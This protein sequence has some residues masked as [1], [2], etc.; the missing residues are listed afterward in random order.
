MLIGNPRCRSAVRP[1][2]GAPEMKTK[3]IVLA[4]S[5]AACG[6]NLHPVDEDQTAIAGGEDMTPTPDVPVDSGFFAGF[7]SD[8]GDC[9]DHTVRVFGRYGYV[10]GTEIE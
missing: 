4:V 10:D 3:H 5:L 9:V 8:P 1:N 7:S 6:D 2:R